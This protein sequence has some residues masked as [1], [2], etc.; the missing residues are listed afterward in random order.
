M[1]RE[2]LSNFVRAA[3]HSLSLRIEISKANNLS[4]LITIANKY[5]FSFNHNDIKSDFILNKAE[6]WFNESKISSIKKNKIN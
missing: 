4:E 6:V 3:E 1:T 5:G 2:G